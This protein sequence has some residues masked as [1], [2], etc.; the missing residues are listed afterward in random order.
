[1]NKKNLDKFFPPLT[2]WM[3]LIKRNVEDMILEDRRKYD[4]LEILS[5]LTGI[6]C[7]IPI[8][9]LKTVDVLLNKININFNGR[10]W[11]L[12]AY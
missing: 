5:L 3:K 7:N 10:G 8:Y 6:K 9:K 12:S 1:M 2:S 11:R 4:R